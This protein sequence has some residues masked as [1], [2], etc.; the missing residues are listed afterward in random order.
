MVGKPEPIEFIPTT[1]QVPEPAGSPSEDMVNTPSHYT[2]GG[3]ECL[4]AIQASMTEDGFKGFLKGNVMKYI[5][6]YEK[7]INPIED[8]KKAQWYLKKLEGM[9]EKG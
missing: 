1:S 3:I 4:D 6:R 2:S 8:L 9:L 5:W 7:K